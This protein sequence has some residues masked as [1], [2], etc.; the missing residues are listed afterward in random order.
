MAWIRKEIILP[1]NYSNEDT[2]IIAEEILNYVVERSKSGKGKDGKAFPKYSKEYM[3]SFEFKASGKSKNV[4][5]TLSGEMLDSLEILE[6]RKGKIVI[7]FERGSNMN[8]RAEGNILGSYGKPDPD[9]KKARN[10]LDIS[11]KEISKIV[12]SIDILPRDI[13]KE[14]SSAAKR[15]AIDLIDNFQFDLEVDE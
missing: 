15:G 9:P 6:A 4:N 14:I 10:F 1:D 8:E 7:G 11:N 13:Q 2:E 5:L 3:E 12:S